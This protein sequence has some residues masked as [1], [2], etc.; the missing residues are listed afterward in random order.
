MQLGVSV[1]FGSISNGVV[2]AVLLERGDLAWLVHSRMESY[3]FVEVMAEIPREQVIQAQCEQRRGVRHG[4]SYSGCL[5]ML[6][7][8]RGFKEQFKMWMLR[9]Y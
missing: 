7:L 1:A 5:Y 3:T 6:A 4:L 2:M 9:N 8:G